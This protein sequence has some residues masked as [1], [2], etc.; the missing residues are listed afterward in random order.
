MLKGLEE[1]LLELSLFSSFFML[2]DF[3]LLS[4]MNL[5]KPESS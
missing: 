4:S 3:I 1:L 2:C 5:F